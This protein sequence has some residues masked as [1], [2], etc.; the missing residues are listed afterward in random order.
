MKIVKKAS[1]AIFLCKSRKVRKKG[2]KLF[3][4]SQRMFLLPLPCVSLSA[5]KGMDERRRVLSFLI[6]WCLVMKECWNSC[7]FVHYGLYYSVGVQREWNI[8]AHKRYHN[9]I[10]FCYLKHH[11][12]G[13]VY[14]IFLLLYSSVII[15]YVQHDYI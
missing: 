2:R 15:Q 6:K 13:T 10:L 5:K 14:I 12:C 7:Q 8:R 3:L 11:M 1:L 9:R 4:F